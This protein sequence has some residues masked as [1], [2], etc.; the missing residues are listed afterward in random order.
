MKSYLFVFLLTS[1]SLLAQISPGDLTEAHKDL[2]G[3]SN[4]TKCHELGEEVKNDKCLD[5]HS[6]IRTALQSSSGYHSSSEVKSKKCFQ[7]HS[8][9]HGR[10]FEII[11]FDKNSFNHSA[12]GFS[13]TGKHS[14]AECDDCHKK[15]FIQELWE[16]AAKI[17][18]IQKNLFLQ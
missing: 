11:H 17:A 2:E 5:C 9:H 10:N 3:M 15:D 6:E 1:I 14:E 7:C 8:E 18:T 16:Q 4:C 12:T 13:L